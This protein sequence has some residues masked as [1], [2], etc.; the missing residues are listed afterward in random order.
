M[1]ATA[2]ASRPRTQP[3]K[4]S[5]RIYIVRQR[6][7]REVHLRPWLAATVAVLGGLFFVTYFA[8]T[9]YLVFRDD[10]L[11]A[12]FA[13]QARQRIAYEDR[14]AA[15]RADIDRLSGRQLLNQEE[16]EERLEDVASRQAMLDERQKSLADLGRAAKSA[17]LI[18]PASD[19][20]EDR[21]TADDE[22]TTGSIDAPAAREPGLTLDVVETS[23]DDLAANQV[24]FLEEIASDAA[25]RSGRIETVLEEVGRDVP[26][27]N[28]NEDAMGGP[29]IAM[30][31]DV[32]PETFRDAVEVVTAQVERFETLK[33]TASGL[34][35]MTPM[36]RASI[37]S[38]FGVRTDPF[39]R[40]PAMHTGIDFRAP[41]GEPAKATAPGK[42][43]SAGYNR[44]YGYM[45]EIDHGRGLTTRFAHLSKI[46]A[47]KGQIVAKGDIIGRTGSTGRST[48]PHLH[49]EIRVN[50]R[51][52][53]PMTFIR[54]GEHLSPL[55]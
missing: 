16:F 18:M 11:A 47:K 31:S 9:G 20:S 38:R 14:I 36:S 55:L 22:L 52:I 1:M 34:P 44:G 40:R 5:F 28:G 7:I 29:F 30:P 24:S 54:A 17:G 37:T 49:Y 19:T 33:Q 48:G 13:R 23:L 46:V 53:D 32:D 50:G 10:L 6:A 4:P 39:R 8:A 42:V 27:D 41:S 21:E 3:K 12:S 51:P 45:V 43:I 25:E 15:L 2:A 35:L 26:K